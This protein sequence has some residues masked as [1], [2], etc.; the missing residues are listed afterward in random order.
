MALTEQQIA[1]GCPWWTDPGW[2]EADPHLRRLRERPVLLPAPLVDSIDVA[3][4]AIHVVKGPRQ[5]GKS[6]DLKL[7]ARRK[8]HETADRFSTIYIALDLLVGQSP[9]DIDATVRLAKRLS[10]NR[11]GQLVLLDEVTAVA[12]W[13]VAV[14]AL[15]DA[16][17]IDRD[18]VVC[19]G[20][21]ALD[22]GAE[23]MPGRRGAG[24]DHLVLPQSF[25]NFARALVPSLPTPP[26]LSVAKLLT[27]RGSA[28]LDEAVIHGSQLE[29]AL[30][31]YLVFGGLPAAVSEAVGSGTEPSA[32]VRNVL[33]DSLG[34]DALQRG[35]PEPAIFALFARTLRSLGSKTS[36]SSLAREM[37]VPLGSARAGH[38]RPAD[39]R[40]VKEHVESL[41][42]AYQLLVVYFWRPDADAAD[43]S[44][45]KKLYF[46]DP[47]LHTVA[48]DRAPGVPWNQPA[49]IENAVALALYRRYEPE[50]QR[51]HGFH[52]PVR[53]H[54]WET[55]RREIDFVC[56]PRDELDAVEVKY[57]NG[58]SRTYAEGLRRTLPRG[59]AVVVTRDD[60]HA[61]STTALVPAHL[62][63][64]LV[65]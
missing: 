26:E 34:R 42:T 38:G 48:H 40:T 24:R 9:T 55:A 63:L 10:G 3:L 54:V 2:E 25:P 58:V 43:L 62:F 41:A 60:L 28:A 33:I 46:A 65:G 20:S 23:G 12:N 44:R 1:A 6:T 15:W 27:A 5:V 56:G 52:L 32:E 14:K 7:L 47:L 19:T 8:L 49:L 30:R 53:L 22:L 13:R 64:W 18:I 37:D 17:V 45:D 59:P 51:L 61:D 39:Y 16:G 57:Q 50:D 11:S 29:D 35:A 31:K 4:P 36:Y 21:S